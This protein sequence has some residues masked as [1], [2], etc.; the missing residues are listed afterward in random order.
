LPFLGWGAFQT[1]Y[2][3]IDP[4]ALSIVSGDATVG[5]YAAA[6]RLVCTTLFLPGAISTALMPTLSRLHRNDPAEFLHLGR[7]MLSIVLLCG[8][9]IAFVLI[10]APK[11]LL[12]LLHYPE[13]FAAS[14]PVLR[15]GGIGVLLWYVA[16]VLGTTVVASDGQ[17]GMFRAAVVATFVSV[18]SC[19][20]LS[21][22]TQRA[23][24][25]GAIGAMVSDIITES[26]LIL[27][28]ARLL[29][30]GFLGAESFLLAGKYCL[31]A[32]PMCLYLTMISGIVGLLTGV[33]GG[34]VVYLLL[35]WAMGCVDPRQL[36]GTVRSAVKTRSA[37]V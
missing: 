30:K 32:I 11:A 9:P 31:A 2:G 4:L 3:Q 27:F 10:C 18:P 21:Y 34:G 15:I 12:D 1:L 14:I 16:S 33:I 24:G 5:W 35:C 22:L 19:F 36:L 20:L 8:V 6:F 28:Y 25:N 13:S 26:V 23:W 29:P 37:V 7:R 17:T